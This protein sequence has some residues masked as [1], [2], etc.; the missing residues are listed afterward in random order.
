MR[1][2]VHARASRDDN[3]SALALIVNHRHL[4]SRFSRAR[5]ELRDTH[6]EA[7]IHTYKTGTAFTFHIS[8]TDAWIQAL[9]RRH[10][11]HSV[12][13][14]KIFICVVS[15]EIVMLYDLWHRM[16]KDD[17][18]TSRMSVVYYH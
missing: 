13:A 2:A 7:F 11:S 6:P 1:V 16:D 5:T 14:V 12:S 15:T 3:G 8:H 9:A 4:L 18:V 17:F 10:L